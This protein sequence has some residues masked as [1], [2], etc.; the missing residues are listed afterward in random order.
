MAMNLMLPIVK[1]DTV[2]VK[3]NPRLFNALCVYNLSGQ[4]SYESL[5]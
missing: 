1:F 5:R 3:W 2:K 4:V